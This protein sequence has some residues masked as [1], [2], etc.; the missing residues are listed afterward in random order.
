MSR[1]GRPSS[2][3]WI[4]GYGNP[5]RR[6]DGVG[7]YIVNRLQPFFK[8]R[9]DIRLQIL[10]QLEPDVV[11]TLKNAHTILFVDATV[12]TLALGWQ[13]A[14]VRPEPGAM[15]CLTHQATPSWVLGLLQTLYHRSPAV[16]MISVRGN[17][18][19]FGSGLSPET[20]KRVEQ[21]MGEIIEFVLTQV[22]EKDRINQIEAKLL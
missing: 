21:V 14:E 5:Q 7:P 11:D 3:F 15:P 9:N 2:Y 18:F 13:W 20:Q 10:H 19:G 22:S 6:D 4:V 1:A 17:D 12:E 16:W 8:Q